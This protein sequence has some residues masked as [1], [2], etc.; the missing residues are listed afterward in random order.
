MN[1][2]FAIDDT[3][4]LRE[5]GFSVVRGHTEECNEP[6][7]EDRTRT[8]DQD[9]AARTD[10][11]AGADLCRNSGGE[12]LEGAHAALLLFAEE[13]KAAKNALPAF[14]EAANLHEARSDGEVEACADEQDDQHVIREI[15]IDGNDDVQQSFFH[16]LG[17]PAPLMVRTILDY[18]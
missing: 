12:R 7:P 15:R 9:R 1:D 10:D 11:V 13:R 6:H 3:H 18:A 8:T 16:G 4:L 5:H 14:S 2:A 17:S